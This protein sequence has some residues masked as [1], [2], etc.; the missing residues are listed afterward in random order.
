M[1]IGGKDRSYYRL[2]SDDDL[3]EEAK[4][5]PNVELC[6]VLGERLAGLRIS[7]SQE[8]NE[9]RDIRDRMVLA[10]SAA[11]AMQAEIDGYREAING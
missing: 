3:I 1:I 2:A 10:S 8:L 9:L 7:V 11:V 6:I 4:Y 5:N